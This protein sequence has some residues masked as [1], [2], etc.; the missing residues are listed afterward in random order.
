MT[1]G[2][3]HAKRPTIK[4]WVTMGF[5]APTRDARGDRI[6]FVRSVRAHTS[7]EAGE[8]V[9][10]NTGCTIVLSPE[11]AVSLSDKLSREAFRVSAVRNKGN[12]YATK[13]EEREAREA[14]R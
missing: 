8:L 11:S 6:M 2:K 5:D 10:R 9:E 12:L 14:G 1:R 7:A 3:K 4:R 13:R